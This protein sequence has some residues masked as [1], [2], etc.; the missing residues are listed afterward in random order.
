MIQDFQRSIARNH[1]QPSWGRDLD[2][3]GTAAVRVI[4][5]EPGFNPNA[6][7]AMVTTPTWQVKVRHRRATTS[8]P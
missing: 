8:R 7:H 2:T 5:D 1:R 6:T 4:D 3:D